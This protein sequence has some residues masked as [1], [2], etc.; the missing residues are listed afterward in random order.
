MF[1]TAGGRKLH[2]SMRFCNMV[3]RAILLEG[4]GVGERAQDVLGKREGK[5]SIC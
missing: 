2:A 4:A 1:H 5:I 3:S